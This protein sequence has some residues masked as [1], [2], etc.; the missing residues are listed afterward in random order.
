MAC[1]KRAIQF[2][3]SPCP[4]RAK[5]SVQE[6]AIEVEAQTHFMIYT[7]VYPAQ[8]PSTWFSLGDGLHR[9][10]VYERENWN[11]E[12]VEFDADV[13]TSFKIFKVTFKTSIDNDHELEVI[14]DHWDDSEPDGTILEPPVFSQN[15]SK[16]KLRDVL[17]RYG[18]FLEDF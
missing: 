3:G 8:Y 4:K 17:S 2:T 9:D 13:Q 1:L 11:H 5:P 15:M 7:C 10:L 16:A 12:A 18:R 14:P 6:K